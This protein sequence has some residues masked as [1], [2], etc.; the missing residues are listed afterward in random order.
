MPR[1]NF[2]KGT[3]ADRKN[4]PADYRRDSFL[5][6]TQR[7]ITSSERVEDPETDAAIK[8]YQRTLRIHSKA[9]V[10]APAPAESSMPPVKEILA[11]LAIVG[12]VAA[13]TLGCIDT[14]PYQYKYLPGSNHSLGDAYQN[15]SP[16]LSI[17]D[18]Y[19]LVQLSE[20]SISET[21][22]SETNWLN[23][24]NLCHHRFP[25][26]NAYDVNN[27]AAKI[28]K[29]A[30]DYGRSQTEASN[31]TKFYCNFSSNENPGDISG[32]DD[33]TMKG[34]NK[35]HTSEKDGRRIADIHIIN[36]PDAD[37]SEIARA[38][39]ETSTAADEYHRS[40]F[41]A[42]NWTK[43]CYSVSS[44]T[45]PDEVNSEV[46]V[47]LEGLNES[48]VRKNGGIRFA[49]TNHALFPDAGAR[50][51]T[52]LTPVA[53]KTAARSGF[54][55]DDCINLSKLYCSITPDEFPNIYDV[56]SAVVTAIKIAKARHLNTDDL[57]KDINFYHSQSPN[58]YPSDINSAIEYATRPYDDPSLHANPAKNL[59]EFVQSGQ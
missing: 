54:S 28:S 33:Y 3:K 25:K 46:N 45:S 18:A 22:T 30:H 16:D 29:S 13:M 55:E 24:V 39:V 32:L 7:N 4:I 58:S 2:W 20:G 57:T 37:A 9:K 56:N 53:M 50:D 11:T 43:F 40:K 15:I 21:N 17:R 10:S 26:A 49:K 47:I 38:M 27:A 36:Y 6:S 31:W 34:L 12:L 51:I 52:T 5:G 19:N 14:S 1:R 44:H 48:G 59:R 35:S 41:E 23:L 8:Y 42:A